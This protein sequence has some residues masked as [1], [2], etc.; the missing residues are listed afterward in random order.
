M[1][2]QKKLLP[3]LSVIV[4]VVMAGEAMLTAALP[5]MSNEF[6]VPGVFESWILPMVLLVGAAAAPFIGTAGDQYGRRRL[7]L[8]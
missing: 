4:L 7:L 3:I 1:S 5:V 8:I 2:G 6:D